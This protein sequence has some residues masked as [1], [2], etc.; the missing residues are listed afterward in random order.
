MSEN[1]TGNRISSIL[2]SD[3]SPSKR[4]VSFQDSSS[5]ASSP[6]DMSN[7]TVADL[8][9]EVQQ[10]AEQLTQAQMDLVGEKAVRKKKEKNL[11]KLAKELQKRSTDMDAKN[12]QYNKVSMVSFF[13]IFPKHLL[14]STF[15]CS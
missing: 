15:V 2:F 5:P 12:A 7:K 8:Q 9:A 13:Q 1:D 3:P 14:T 6:A 10:L 11:V 4:S